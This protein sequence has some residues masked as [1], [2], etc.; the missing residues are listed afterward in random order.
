MFTVPINDEQREYA[1]ALVSSTNFGQRNT[2]SEI[3]LDTNGNKPQQYTGIL[4][5]VVLADLLGLPRPVK[6]ADFDG[7]VDFTI[8]GYCVDLKTMARDFDVSPRWVN[9]LWQSQCEDPRSRTEIYAFASIN[10]RKRT[11]TFCGLFPRHWVSAEYGVNYIPAGTMRD[12]RKG[13]KVLQQFPLKAGMYEVPMDRLISVALP[14][15]IP[16]KVEHIFL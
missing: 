3:G 11:F 8:R 7:G 4:G 10:R 13:G 6:T 5:Q 2:R 15:E 16:D 12:L 1:W 9:N 14:E